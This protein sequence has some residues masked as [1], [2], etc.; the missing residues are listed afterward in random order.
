VTALEEEDERQKRRK[1]EDDPDRNS[2]LS[3]I[4]ALSK[5][6]IGKRAVLERVLLAIISNG[7]VLFEDYPGLAKTLIARSFA[8]AT[9]CQFRRVQ[10][11]PDLLP[12]DI[13]GTYVFNRSNSQ[14]ELRRGPIFTNVMLAD[15]INRAPPRTQSA[16][17]EA[18]QE[19]QV[20]IE[21]DTFKLESPFVVLATQNPIEYEGTYP[22]PEAQ[23]DRFIMKLAI[24]YPTLD[25]E[26]KIMDERLLR[27]DDDIMISPLMSPTGI[28]RIRE[29]VEEIHIEKSVMK[30]IAEVVR[31]TRTHSDIEVGVSPRGTL[32]LMKLA[33][34][35]AWLYG[36]SYVLPDDVKELA[37]P[38]LGHR[39]VLKPELWLKGERYAD[40]IIKDILERVPV[41]KVD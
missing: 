39:L 25:E 19:R 33:R 32:A 36:R 29:A 31:L 41:P 18:M 15:E 2:A 35:R 17:L 30:Y 1:R 3:T 14:F 7:H 21:N 22:L 28:L 11:T 4:E 12:A 6:I 27:K 20:T 10:F 40:A 38:T 24:G 34:A 16:L 37:N 9:G 23:L 13:I 5:V 8:E 26:L